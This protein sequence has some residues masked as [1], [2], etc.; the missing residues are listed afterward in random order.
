MSTAIGIDLGTTFSVV[1]YLENGKARVIPSSEGGNLIP[2]VV[3]FI[4]GGFQLTGKLARAQAAANPI[5]TIASIKRWMGSDKKIEIEGKTYTPQE[6]SGF[7]L[8]KVKREAEAYIG[9]KVEKAVITV[10]AYFNDNQ[11]QATMDAAIFARLDVMRII[12][13]PTAASLAYGLHEKDLQHIL[14]WDLGGGTF[15]VSI[16]ELGQ[17]VFEVKAVNGDTHLGGDDW[18]QKIMD[19]AAEEYVKIHKIDIR[20]DR[21]ALQRLKEA[22]E[23][24]KRELS[25]KPLTN[26]RI[27]FI[28]QGRDL[29]ISLTREKFEELSCDLLEKM[30]TPSKQ[31][32]KDANLT[33]KNIDRVILVGGSTR[34][35]AV[36]QLA[37]ELFDREPYKDINPDEVVAIGAAIQAGVLAGEIKNVTLVDVAPISLGIETMGG[38][39]TRII[40]RNTSVPTTCGQIFTTAY[41]NQTQVDIYILQG[42]RALAADNVSLG[43]FNLDN[44]PIAR[45]GEPQIE[46]A[47]HIDANGILQVSAFDLHTENQKSININS[48]KRLSRGQINKMLEEA[49]RYAA[50][51]EKRKEHIQIGICAEGMIASAQVVMEENLEILDKFQID[52]IEKAILKVKAA[53]A[54]GKS[55]EM[56]LEMDELRKIIEIV[57]SEIRDK[58]EK[59]KK[60]AHSKI[61]VLK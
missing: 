5:R 33:A 35:P 43:K 10:P 8:R 54:Q 37:R 11:R 58:K 20:E 44:I 50:D 19:Y 16:L 36:Q 25:Q 34:M 40:E 15:D 24:A 26:I 29:E 32:L 57:C 48:S 39:F 60:M 52:E 28:D 18:D 21:I 47:F 45:R 6:I 42:E 53:L 13:E 56:K 46:V 38:I 9:E 22:S 49:E 7:I 14:V 51:D 27:P 4:D 30:V 12:N 61:G 17:G 1:A 31:A 59:R 2:S 23:R 55:E 3:A 41:D